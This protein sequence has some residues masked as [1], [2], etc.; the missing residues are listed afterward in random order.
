MTWP[1]EVIDDHDDEICQV[2]DQVLSEHLGGLLIDNRKLIVDCFVEAC[3][4]REARCP[5]NHIDTNFFLENELRR[6][7]GPTHLSYLLLDCCLALL[8]K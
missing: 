3:W 1:S 6:Y 2:K 5:N 7:R 4:W 8:R